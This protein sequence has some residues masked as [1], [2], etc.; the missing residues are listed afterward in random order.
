MTAPLVVAAIGLWLSFGAVAPADAHA[1]RH[2]VVPSAWLLAGL[3]AGAILLAA[4]VRRRIPGSAFHPLYLAGLLWL[5][6]LP[7]PMPA[8]FYLW[9]GP[10]TWVLWSVI[11]V[12]L[13]APWLAAA[14]G[15]IGRRAP[16]SQCRLA[17]A[18]ALGVYVAAAWRMAPVLPGGDEPHYL[19]IAQSLLSDRDLRIENN[20]QRRDYAS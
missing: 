10:L 9:Q 11:A 16:K 5:P 17:F 1:P 2:L 13:G 6:W 7:I 8:A 14:G 4:I 3:L 18:I 12:A 15:W 19:I 20:H